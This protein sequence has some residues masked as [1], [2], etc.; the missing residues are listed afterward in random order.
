MDEV[1]YI[2]ATRFLRRKIVTVSAENIRFICPVKSDSIVEIKGSVSKIGRVKLEIRVEVTME[3]MYSENKEK[4]IEAIF[5][6]AAV[7]ENQKPERL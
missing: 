1:A 5:V 4:A 7:S 3:D 2:T 6:F